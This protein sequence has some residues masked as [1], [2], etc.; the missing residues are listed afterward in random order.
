MQEK[1]RI[2][3]IA[4]NSLQI[5]MILALVVLEILSEYRAGIMQH[6]YY[7][8]VHYLATLYQRS[9][10]LFHAIGLSG[11]MV[12]IG[13][14]NQNR[15]SSNRS[16][17]MIRGIVVCL[18]FLAVYFSPSMRQLN[19]Y[20]Y[21]LIVLECFVVLETVGTVVYFFSNKGSNLKNNC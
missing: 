12:F 16:R 21:L 2:T 7:H 8:K 18:L 20:A 5:V 17:H 3:T 9:N 4:I 1:V 15:W 11:C 19:V 14:V 6:L 10:L 13:A